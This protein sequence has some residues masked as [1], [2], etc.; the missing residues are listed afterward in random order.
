MKSIPFI[1]IITTPNHF[2]GLRGRQAGLVSAGIVH[3][4]EAF[5]LLLNEKGRVVGHK[6]SN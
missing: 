2:F 3:L 1:S 6:M 4:S 5:G